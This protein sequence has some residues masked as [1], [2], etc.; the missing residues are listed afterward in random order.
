V[1]D[2]GDLTFAGL[3]LRARGAGSDTP[4]DEAIWH[5]AWWQH[6]KC[7]RWGIYGTEDEALE[8]VAL[9]E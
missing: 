4:V 7:T 1:R 9:R 6:G 8:A 3:R 5:L 2:L